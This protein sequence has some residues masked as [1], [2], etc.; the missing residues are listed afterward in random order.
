[1]IAAGSLAGFVLVEGILQLGVGERLVSR[2]APA[3]LRYSR[4]THHDYLPHS[5]FVR[6]PVGGDRF[7]PVLNQFNAQGLR[8]PELA[9][10][11]R[12]RVLLLGDSTILAETV[13]FELT[14]CAQLNQRLGSVL[15]CVAKGVASWSPTPELSWLFH[16]GL[17][18]GPD[19]VLLFLDPNDFYRGST[20]GW[21]DDNYRRLAIYEGH[22]PV[23][24]RVPLEEGPRRIAGALKRLESVRL[25]IWARDEIGTGWRRDE[26]ESARVAREI[27]R[28][29]QDSAA[30]SGELA[31]NV[32]ATL[33]VVKDMA[34]LLAPHGIRLGVL[35]VPQPF[36]WD[37]ESRLAKQVLGWSPEF[38][39][40][41]T[42]LEQRVRD[43]VE[44]WGIRYLDLRPALQFAKRER[45]QERLYFDFDA[46]WNPGA[47]EL[48]ARWL[49]EPITRD[50]VPAA[51]PAG[52]GS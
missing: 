29:E 34:D 33:G 52:P 39:V 36:A 25:A 5:S 12:P 20:M 16:S 48:V 32:D 9:A 4:E 14:I 18:L 19:L 51:A 11:R 42:A 43:T 7:G 6:R 8:G 24:Y 13:P 30:W 26:P 1:M 41:G 17:D 50:L 35:M 37:D 10:K 31:R 46:H 28:L 3:S 44:R 21:T 40:P 45:P 23:S 22:V 47:H 49:E 2:P 15:E 27:V 38:T